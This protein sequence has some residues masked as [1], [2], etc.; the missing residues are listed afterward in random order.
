[1]LI[2]T[3]LSLPCH[4]NSHKIHRTNDPLLFKLQ[5][6]TPRKITSQWRHT[7]TDTWTNLYN[8]IQCLDQLIQVYL[9]QGKILVCDINR[10][11]CMYIHTRSPTYL[12]RLLYRWLLSTWNKLRRTRGGTA[13]HVI[14]PLDIK[15]EKPAD[16]SLF[17][18]ESTWSV[19][20]PCEVPR[21]SQT[22]P[23]S[24]REYCRWR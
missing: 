4:V 15:R 21:I 23:V 10:I 13:S 12:T 8:S 1:M 19:S 18:D 16:A 5:L 24:R 7:V 3:W 9:D 17:S 14:R 20:C 6:K 22:S 2:I 11:W